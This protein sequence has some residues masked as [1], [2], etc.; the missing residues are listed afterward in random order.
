MLEYGKVEEY[1]TVSYV[2]MPSECARLGLENA[3]QSELM[4]NVMAKT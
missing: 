2:R 3:S 1:S 4:Q